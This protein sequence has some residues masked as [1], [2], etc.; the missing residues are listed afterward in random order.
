MEAEEGMLQVNW[1]NS[2]NNCNFLSISINNYLLLSE[3][4]G[5]WNHT[6]NDKEN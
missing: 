5:D 3:F 4:N 1:Q 6:G 2:E